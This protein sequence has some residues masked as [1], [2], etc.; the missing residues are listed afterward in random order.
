VA[1][2]AAAQ[3]GGGF[4]APS[5]TESM[6]DMQKAAEQIGTALVFIR[7]H[8]SLQFSIKN[9]GGWGRRGGGGEA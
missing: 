3:G 5:G 4:V 1:E 8:H 7:L 9:E 2:Q 6:E